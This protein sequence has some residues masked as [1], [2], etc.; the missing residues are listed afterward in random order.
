MSADMIPCSARSDPNDAATTGATF[1]AQAK[2]LLDDE[3]ENPSV[4]TVQA[5]CLMAKY[6]AYNGRALKGGLYIVM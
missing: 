4:T 3:L 5:L 2:R 1:F 6:E